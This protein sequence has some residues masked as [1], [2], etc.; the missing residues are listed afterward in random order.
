MEGISDNIRYL[1][2]YRYLLIMSFLSLCFFFFGGGGG[3]GQGDE[4][5][6]KKAHLDFLECV[7]DF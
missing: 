7:S 1:S 5:L 2:H 4:G 3:G 6:G